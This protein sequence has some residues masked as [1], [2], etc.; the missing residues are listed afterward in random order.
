MLK[1][2]YPLFPRLSKMLLMLIIKKWMGLRLEHVENSVSSCLVQA[3][4]GD[5]MAFQQLLAEHYDMIYQVAYRFTGHQANAEDITQ[6]VCITLADKIRSFRGEAKFSTWLYRIVIHAC[7]DAD[8]KHQHQHDKLENYLAF[9]SQLQE[10]N[11]KHAEQIIWLYRE[12]AQMAEPYR[13]TA[14]LVLAQ[15]LSHAE[16]GQI[17]GC[18][19]ATISWRMH[20]V[21]NKLKAQLESEHVE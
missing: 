4:A 15:N 16:V 20:E 5:R 19:E 12:L 2:L 7:L 8:R 21:R 13:E 6:D 3:Q 1:T 11:Q 9:A 10:T 18:S 17:L 14:F